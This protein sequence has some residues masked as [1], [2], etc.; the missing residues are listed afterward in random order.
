MPVYFD[1]ESNCAAIAEKYFGSGRACEDFIYVDLA[2]GIGTG[3]ITNGKLYSNSSGM[4][5]ELGHTSIDWQET[6]AAV[7][8]KD[9]W[10]PIHPAM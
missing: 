8:I 9:V 2:N 10:K 4:V 1:G 6:S 7:E 5:C 3:V